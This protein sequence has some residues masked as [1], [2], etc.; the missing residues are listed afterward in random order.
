MSVLTCP[1][2]GQ[3][4]SVVIPGKEQIKNTN[5]YPFHYSSVKVVIYYR[6]KDKK[7]LKVIAKTLS[8]KT[9]NEKT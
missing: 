8:V 7:K 4:N 9:K 2:V 6:L 1:K 3:S 5:C